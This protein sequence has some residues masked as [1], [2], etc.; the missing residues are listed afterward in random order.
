[1][2]RSAADQVATYNYRLD[3]SWIHHDSALE[4]VVYEPHELVAAIDDNVVSDSAL[5]P[6]YDEIRQYKA[7]IDHARALAKR[8]HL[9]ITLDTLRDLYQFLAPE[10]TDKGQVKYRR[11]IPLHRLYFHEIA[12]PDKIGPRMRQLLGWLEDG[13]ARKHM[14]PTRAA[15]KA[16]YQLLQIFPFPKHSGKVARL[17]MNAMLMHAGYPPAI[18]HSTDRQ[19][20]YE[21][22]RQGPD[23]VATVIHDA[24]E[25]AVHSGL[26][27]F[28]AIHGIEDT[29]P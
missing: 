11:D 22:L 23:E 24:L 13:E 12:P 10:E 28:H 29:N 1:M 17:M 19:G 3:V 18:L 5:M 2:S 26:R 27:Y 16:H 9:D 6:V 8:P 15:S 14:H 20:Y 7:A 25:N 4:G 21:A